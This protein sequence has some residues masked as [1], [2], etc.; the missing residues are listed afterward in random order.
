MIYNS[1]LEEVSDLCMYI[2]I[3]IFELVL[4]IIHYSSTCLDV[5]NINDLNNLVCIQVVVGLVRSLDSLSEWEPNLF[6]ETDDSS[7]FVSI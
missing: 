5:S 7:R 6:V 1:R 2:Y 4:L 3:Y